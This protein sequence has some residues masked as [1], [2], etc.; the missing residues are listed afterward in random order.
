M[1]RSPWNTNM[2]RP[3]ESE[4]QMFFLLTGDI[5]K[6]KNVLKVVVKIHKYIK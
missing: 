1:Y 3:F 4:I 5:G 2:E 6:L